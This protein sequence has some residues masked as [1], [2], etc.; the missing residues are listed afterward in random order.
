[1][2]AW[3]GLR[4]L[5]SSEEHVYA[6]RLYV[7]ALIRTHMLDYDIF[8]YCY[9]RVYVGTSLSLSLRLLGTMLRLRLVRSPD[10]SRNP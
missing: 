7:R 6:L 1:M 2:W 4:D 3:R 8:R 9:V 10:T 5:Q